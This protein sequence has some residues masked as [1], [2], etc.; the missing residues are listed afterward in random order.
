MPIELFEKVVND[1]KSKHRAERDML[2][3]E[4][5]IFKKVINL[6]GAKIRFL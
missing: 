2:M 1:L 4:V 5:S 6:M 3:S